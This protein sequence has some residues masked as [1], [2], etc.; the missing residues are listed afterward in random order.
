M[1]AMTGYVDILAIGLDLGSCWVL[2]S[3]TLS[4]Y[5]SVDNVESLRLIEV[6]ESQACSLRDM[7][8]KYGRRDD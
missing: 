3:S 1:Y 5:Q 8:R 7:M 6:A 4:Q 2:A